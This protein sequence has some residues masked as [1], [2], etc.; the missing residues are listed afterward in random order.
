MTE[1]R[2]F[3][4]AAQVEITPP[5]GTA[6]AGDFVPHY[7]R[8]IHDPLY[9]KALVMKQDEVTIAIV[10]VDVCLMA[11]DYMD[12]IRASIHEQTSIDPNHIT[13][14]STHT[15]AGGS[16]I[17]LLGGAVDYQYTRFLSP[18]IVES[19]VRAKSA[20]QPAQ[21]AFGSVSVPDFVLC[22]R[23]LMH[24]NY[25]PYN[26]ITRQA[27]R[28]KTN[29][30]GAEDQ[31]VAPTATPDP[32][33][34]FVALK[35]HDDQW[36]AILGNY[37]LHY[38]GDWPDDTITADFFGEFAAQLKQK[39][40]ADD[41]FVG[42]MSNGTSGD[43][44]C[45]DFQ[46]P[47][48]LPTGHFAK[49]TLIGEALAQRVAY[50][51][52]LLSWHRD[53]PLAL[54]HQTLPVQVRKPSHD[55]YTRAREE[56]VAHDLDIQGLKP[57]YLQR[58]YDREQVLLSLYP[59]TIAL[60]IQVIQLGDLYI[61]ALPGEFFAETGLALKAALAPT[62]YFSISMANAYGGY[63]PP[64]HELDRGGYET[65]RARSSYLEREAESV[66]RETV[67]RLARLCALPNE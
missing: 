20:M 50:A 33:L 5:L 27:D 59:D 58:I 15:H 29:P 37:S 40:Q 23:Y 52:P 56:F 53:V 19:V 51:L 67:V 4:G 26:P 6:I 61:G 31:I 54:R 62:R 65:W 8:F 57:D 63:I 11:T 17:E 47:D 41:A 3:A 60:L 18:L 2:F 1:P 21:M 24:P 22:R 39:L 14:S 38:V 25:V 10:V 34:S 13:L 55:E 30:F 35:D 32:E 12:G 7:A 44:N 49:T 48:R 42:V 66:V 43:V 9:A 46:H 16:V 36:I 28:V 64:A 45:W